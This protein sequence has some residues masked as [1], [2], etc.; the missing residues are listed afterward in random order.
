[1]QKELEQSAVKE[2]GQENGYNW[3]AASLF[4]LSNTVVS[5]FGNNFISKIEFY[6]FPDVRI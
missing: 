1:M 4:E 2:T 5:L 6:P 3:N